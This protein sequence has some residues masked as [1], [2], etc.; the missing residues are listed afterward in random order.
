MTMIVYAFLQHRRIAK[1][2][3]KKRI[4]GRHLSQACPPC[5]TPSSTTS[6]ATTSAVS[7]LQ[8]RLAILDIA[9]CLAGLR[10]HFHP[11]V[12]PK[13]KSWKSIGQGP[14]E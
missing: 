7:A 3:R 2:G 14:R 10:P 6:S 1:A 4:N 9:A 8:H 12:V 13:M 11:D 5:V